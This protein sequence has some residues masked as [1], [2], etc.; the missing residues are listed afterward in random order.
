[1]TKTFERGKPVW[2]VNKRTKKV[3]AGVY[4]RIYPGGNGHIIYTEH[5]ELK[6]ISDDCLFATKSEALKI[7][8]E[9][10][11]NLWEQYRTRIKNIAHN[12]DQVN[13]QNSQPTDK[14]NKAYK[15]LYA[16][17]LDWA[18]ERG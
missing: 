3:Y 17:Y 12:I 14:E 16:R 11:Y 9:Y 6:Y 13:K 8:Y 10:M 15:R 2:Y 5:I 7:L 1:M 4:I 18:G